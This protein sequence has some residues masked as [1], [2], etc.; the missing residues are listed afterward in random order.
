VILSP[1]DKELI[2]FPYLLSFVNESSVAIRNNYIRKYIS[3]A[4]QVAEATA[5][6]SMLF[7]G[8]RNILGVMIPNPYKKLMLH[9]IVPDSAIF[10]QKAI[11]AVKEWN[12]EYIFL[13]TIDEGVVDAFKGV[14]KDKLLLLERAR[15]KPQSILEESGILGEHKNYP[16]RQ[17]PY[18]AGLEYLIDLVMLSKCDAYIGPLSCGSHLA[19]DLNNN[20]YRNRFI[21]DLGLNPP[22]NNIFVGYQNL[23]VPYPPSCDEVLDKIIP[24]GFPAEVEFLPKMTATHNFTFFS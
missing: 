7:N 15:I 3:F 23:F 13:S 2:G 18:T 22:D 21:F 4:P 17:S 6:K 11:E 14:F 10:L 9:P 12:M 1:W 24:L 20:Q 8:K 16:T 19:I 5:E